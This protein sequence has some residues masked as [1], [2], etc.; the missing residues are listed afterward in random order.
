MEKWI[1]SGDLPNFRKLR[2][3]SQVFTTNADVD[4]AEHLEPWIQWYSMHTGLPYDVHG[5]YHLTDG[6]KANYEDIWQILSVR[7]ERS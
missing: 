3:Q 7:P 5:V 2:D 4:T 1:A 6:P